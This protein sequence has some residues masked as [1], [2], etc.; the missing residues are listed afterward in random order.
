MAELQDPPDVDQHLIDSILGFS[1]GS[2]ADDNVGSRALLNTTAVPHERVPMLESA[3]ERLVRNL[4]SSVRKMA[5]DDVEVTLCEVT[6]TR[7]GPYL[8]SIPLPAMLAIVKAT[9][10]HGQF[11]VSIGA[12]LIY[13]LLEL[14]LGGG[15][16]QQKSGVE[17]RG[18]TTIETQIARL[19]FEAILTSAEEAFNTVTPVEFSIDR[20]ETSPRFAAIAPPASLTVLARFRIEIG[21]VSGEFELAIP[22]S[23]L[24][25][26][27]DALLTSY[28][29][30][31]SGNDEIWR[32]HLAAQ[33]AISQA[34][35]SA[36]LYEAKIPLSKVLQLGVGDTLMLGMRPQDSIDLRCEGVT[37][38]RGRMGR[39]DQS[40]AIKVECLQPMAAS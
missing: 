36:V 13:S 21:G 33:A 8:T 39:L 27:R 14:M 3:F 10:W 26:A 17:G 37:L 30:D 7:F 34:T 23:T 6:T 15:F 25:P 18:F 16:V 11:S 12:G 32:T 35:L 1:T 22:Y 9:P 29:G 31:N 40:V 4:K 24:E 28:S 19:L 5:S 2:Q 38:A 20:F